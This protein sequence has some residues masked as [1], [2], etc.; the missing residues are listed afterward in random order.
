MLA[1]IVTNPNQDSS[2][3]NQSQS[4]FGVGANENTINGSP[5][6]INKGSVT[7]NYAQTSAP[8][9]ELI[10]SNVSRRS[11]SKYFVERGGEKAV[12]VAD[13]H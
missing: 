1:A 3:I 8:K 4:I 7:H 9:R 12:T 11:P 10:P 2:Q 5:I 13:I 6:G